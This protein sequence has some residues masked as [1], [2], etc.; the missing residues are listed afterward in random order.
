MNFSIVLENNIMI[1]YCV[2]VSSLSPV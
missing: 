1:C 2:T